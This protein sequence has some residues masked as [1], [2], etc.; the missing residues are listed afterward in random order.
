MKPEKVFALFFTLTFLV[1]FLGSCTMFSIIYSIADGK[2]GGVA[3][4]KYTTDIAIEDRLY[5]SQSQCN[6]KCRVLAQKCLS[7][8]MVTADL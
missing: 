1:I 7:I 6:M 8:Q 4:K 3:K 5:N 2:S